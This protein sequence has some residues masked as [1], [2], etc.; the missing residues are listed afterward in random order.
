MAQHTGRITDDQVEAVRELI[1]A[2]PPGRVAT[3]GDVAAA[4]GLTNPR[5]V[6]WILRVD[7][8]DLPWQRVIRA[9]GRPATHLYPQQLDRLRAEGVPSDD[10]RVDLRRYRHTF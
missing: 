3:Y 4:A 1:R 9:S 6:G 2:I 10:G 7:G 8:A 5:S